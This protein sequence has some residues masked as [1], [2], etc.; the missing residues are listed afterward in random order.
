MTNRC[1]YCSFDPTSDSDFCDEHRDPEAHRREV[2]ARAYQID[3][4]CWI[5]Y[6]GKDKKFKQAVERRR[7]AAIARANAEIG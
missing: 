3:P 5:S 4:E 6:S 1:P 2:M 7:T